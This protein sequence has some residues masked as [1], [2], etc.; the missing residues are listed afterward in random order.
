MPSLILVIRITTTLIKEIIIGELKFF[1]FGT[2]WIVLLST[3]Q[4]LVLNI[5]KQNALHTF[6]KENYKFDKLTIFNE[7]YHKYH[8]QSR[9]FF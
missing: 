8:K 3:L 1:I 6:L 9:F 7:T 5:K 2:L 4:I